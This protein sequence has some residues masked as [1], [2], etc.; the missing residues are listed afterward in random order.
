MT[1]VDELTAREREVAHL[2]ASGM[3]YVEIAAALNIS[4]NTVSIHVGKL[5]KKLRVNGRTGLRAS[6][7]K[8]LSS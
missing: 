6:V 3:S 2:Y 5:L 4:R 7:A 1:R 8:K